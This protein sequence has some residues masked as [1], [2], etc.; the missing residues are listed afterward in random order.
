MSK[1]F[2]PALVVVAVSGSMVGINCGGEVDVISHGGP[3]P[4]ST[5]TGGSAASGATGGTTGVGGAGGIAE[6]GTGGLGGWGGSGNSG[7][8]GQ[9]GTGPCATFGDPCTECQAQKCSTDYCTCL[10]DPQ[11]LQLALCYQGCDSV[12]YAPLDPCIQQCWAA[13]P[14]AIANGAKAM[15]CGATECSTACPGYQ[16]NP[17]CEVCMFDT[18]ASEMNACLSN[19]DCAFLVACIDASG[20][21]YDPYEAEWCFQQNP[22]GAAAAS[23]VYQCMDNQCGSEC[24]VPCWYP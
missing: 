3:E 13:H 7:A 10:E 9:G 19:T 18:C 22:D 1:G 14:N 15:H 16:P 2:L 8:G 12:G 20:A 23:L 5:P 4:P 11:C 24:P 6:G 21:E 17:P